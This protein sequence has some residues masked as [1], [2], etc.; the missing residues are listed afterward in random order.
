MPHRIRQDI[1]QYKGVWVFI[2]IQDHVCVLD[3]ALE[4]LSKG[5]ELADRLGEKL[6]AV[7]LGLDAEQYLPVV[8]RYGPD[9][10]IYFSHPSLKHYNSEIF[11]EILADLIEREK[12]SIFLFPSTEAGSDCAPRL[13]MRFFTGLTAHC[14]DLEIADSEEYGNG[15]LSMKRPAFSGNMLA[16][17]ICPYTRPQ[18]ATVQPG[19][20]SKR[21]ISGSSPV[22]MRREYAYDPDKMRIVSLNPPLRWNKPHVQLEEAEIIF[23]GGRGLSSRV[24]FDRL[25]ELAEIMK[26][27]V[28][29]TR[30]PV[31]NSWCGKER[32]IG[33]TGKTIK[34][35][36]YVGFGVSGQ[37]QH[38][39][40]IVDSDV[41]VSVNIDQNAPLNEISDYVIVE[42]AS[43]FLGKLIERIKR[44]IVC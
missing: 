28:G 15:I 8:S 39:A 2:E 25:F 38:T 43:V 19:V 34:P 18:M 21:E 1:R 20:F 44:D 27:E 22:V 13:A 3:G 9:E 26:G 41:I 33:Q 7:M 12:P 6:L 16:T 40:S 31:F 24:K 10:I 42:D 11:P 4:I 37:I 14:I 29:A 17:I 36:L 5:R 32:M 30:V 35:K 23:A